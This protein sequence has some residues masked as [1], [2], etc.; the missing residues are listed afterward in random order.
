[1]L[2]AAIKEDTPLCDMRYRVEALAAG[3][4]AKKAMESV[5]WVQ[6]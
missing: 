4:V 2:A 3:A 6:G 5:S 1:M